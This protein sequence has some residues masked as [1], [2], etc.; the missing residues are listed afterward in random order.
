MQMTDKAESKKGTSWGIVIVLVLLPA[1]GIA[2]YYTIRNFSP[3]PRAN[4]ATIAKWLDGSPKVTAQEWIEDDT[5]YV[6][7]CFIDPVGKQWGCGIER[8]GKPLD[9]TFAEWYPNNP[10][11]TDKEKGYGVP[12]STKSY[13]DG[14][15]HGPWR[16]YY[17]IG[18]VSSE[19]IYRY[20]KKG[21]WKVFSP[22][23]EMIRE[24]QSVR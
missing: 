4:A 13:K 21:T 11:G 7:L 2:A 5:P 3:A 19:I 23:G 8:N 6:K 24:M 12:R 20:G 16:V 10:K 14:K 15:P 9:G 17:E 1:V 22:D 18:T